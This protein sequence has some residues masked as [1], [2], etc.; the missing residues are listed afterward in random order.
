[1]SVQA[2]SPR[3]A[4][5]KVKR[6]L[7]GRLKCFHCEEYGCQ[8]RQSESA[9]CQCRLSEST[10]A[11]SAGCPRVRLSVQ[12]VREYGCQ[13]R[14]SESAAVSAGSPRVQ[15]VSAGCPRVQAVSTVHAG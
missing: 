2:S 7:S 5:C 10:A 15:A 4:N 3:K 9:G 12:A 14:L 6:V 11:V 13:C 8:C 1:M